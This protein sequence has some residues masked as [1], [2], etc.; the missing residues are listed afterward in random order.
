MNI[1]TIES[2][3]LVLNYNCIGYSLGLAEWINP[4]SIK[5]GETNVKKKILKSIEFL[6]KK[7]NAKIDNQR[8]FDNLY[9]SKI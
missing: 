3:N 2:H 5:I 4:I 1:C 8:A 9:K 7:S 6:F